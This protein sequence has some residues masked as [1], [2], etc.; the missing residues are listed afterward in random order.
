MEEPLIFDD[1]DSQSSQLPTVEYDDDDVYSVPSRDPGEIAEQRWRRYTVRNFAYGYALETS[2][3]VGAPDVQDLRDWFNRQALE[4]GD[5]WDAPEDMAVSHGLTFNIHT[6]LIRHSNEDAALQPLQ[7]YFFYERVHDFPKASLDPTAGSPWC[8][9]S[10]DSNDECNFSKFDPAHRIGPPSNSIAFLGISPDRE[11]TW[12][13]RLGPWMFKIAVQVEVWY[14]VL[15]KDELLVLREI[16]QCSTS[17][18]GNQGHANTDVEMGGV[19]EDEDT[20]MVD[21]WSDD[22]GASDPSQDEK[23][24]TKRTCDSVDI[25]PAKRPKI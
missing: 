2:T 10:T 3:F 18:G 19:S 11:F 9:W 17:E 16:H 7:E 22:T 1:E 15:T 12:V 8:F 13:Q 25:R 4:C 5:R 23:Q 24:R 14:D 21:A 20:S 6:S